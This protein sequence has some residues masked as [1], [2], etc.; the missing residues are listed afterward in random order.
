[1]HT[2]SVQPTPTLLR[3][4]IVERILAGNLQSGVLNESALAAELGIS[5]TPVREALLTLPNFFFKSDRRGFELRPME[6]R[7][8]RE[9]YPMIG[10]L[11]CLAIDFHIEELTSQFFIKLRRLNARLRATK[12]PSEA[13]E[14][15]VDWHGTLLSKC[16]N[17][18]LLRILSDLKL[19]VRR[20]ELAYMDHPPQLVQSARQHESITA[21][22]EKRDVPTAKKILFENWMCG[23]EAMTRILEWR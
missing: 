16:K 14:A 17:R 22:L 10:A 1:M 2:M 21:Y 8:V 11:E 5:R 18:T 6:T 3:R 7:E 20:Y 9:I 12:S 19:V 15:D 23:C 4:K 13:V